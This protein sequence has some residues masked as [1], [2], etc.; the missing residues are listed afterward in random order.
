MSIITDKSINNIQSFT[1]Y[2]NITLHYYNNAYN[3]TA[4]R[5]HAM[6]ITMKQ[7]HISVTKSILSVIKTHAPRVIPKN[8]FRMQIPMMNP[9]MSQASSNSTCSHADIVLRVP[10]IMSHAPNTNLKA[11]FKIYKLMIV[12]PMYTPIFS[13]NSSNNSSHASIVLRVPG[14]I[15][16]TPLS[17][18][19][20]RFPHALPTPSFRPSQR[21]SSQCP[22]P[23]RTCAEDTT[24]LM[25]S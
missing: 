11:I 3:N 8:V 19:C 24:R 23:Y 2:T 4:T 16:R 13:N 5:D 22:R 21:T 10:G 20:R 18:R 15:S 17:S 25:R 9:T 12:P 14:L 6:T 1:L 7:M